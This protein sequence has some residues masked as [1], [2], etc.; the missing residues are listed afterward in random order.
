MQRKNFSSK[1]LWEPTIGYSRAV[2]IGDH[3]YISGTTSTD[4]EG[5]ILGKGNPY[6]QTIQIIKNIET[7]LQALGASLKDIVRTRI[8]LTDINNWEEVGKAHAEFFEEIRPACTLVE[9]SSL[10]NP[11]ILVEME[12]DANIL[13]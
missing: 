13:I 11:E 4:K 6:I 12:V 9:I 8:Y 2:R 5:N 3:V 10:I 1:T 7:A